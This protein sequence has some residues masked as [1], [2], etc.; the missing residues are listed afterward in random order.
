M[1]VDVSRPGMPMTASFLPNCGSRLASLNAS[2]I[3]LAMPSYSRE[4]QR[5]PP[6]PPPMLPLYVTTAYLKVTS[7]SSSRIRDPVSS[8]GQPGRP[9][10]LAEGIQDGTVDGRPVAVG[11]RLGPID[12]APEGSDDE[13]G[14][15]VPTPDDCVVISPV[16]PFA[17]SRT[18]GGALGLADGTVAT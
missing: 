9:V 5:R 3:Q 15:W 6:T 2:P 1:A 14:A 12:G 7:P 18:P 8:S 16:V 4:T 10:G 17:P 13:D 11:T